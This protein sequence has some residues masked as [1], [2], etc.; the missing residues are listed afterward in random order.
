MSM[1]LVMRM[2][3]FGLL[4]ALVVVAPEVAG[5][6]AASDP[7]AIKAENVGLYSHYW[8]PSAVHVEPGS[9]VQISNPTEVPHGVEWIAPPGGRGPACDPTVPVGST[10]A[11]SAKSWS[12]SC[13]F[14][15]PGVYVFYCTVHGAA[16]RGQVT[17]GTTGTTTTTTTTTTPTTPTGTTVGTTPTG[18]TPVR[19]TPVSSGSGGTKTSTGDPSTSPHPFVS[20]L[21]GS[22]ASSVALRVARHG[23]HVRG[24]L[25]LSQA[26]AGAHV[27]I[28]VSAKGALLGGASAP[29]VQIGRL[30]R[31]HLSAGTVSFSIELNARAKRVLRRRGRLAVSVTL[32]LRPLEGPVVLVHRSLTLHR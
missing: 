10:A 19:T 25:H 20:P 8:T 11:A 26:G 16:M 7:E 4:G 9:S 17:V 28:E 27:E 23:A 14:T 22:V 6:Q 24:E 12:G 15:T 13:T 2:A 31:A 30:E 1:R 21:L 29:P 5:S 32:A 18:T 3:V